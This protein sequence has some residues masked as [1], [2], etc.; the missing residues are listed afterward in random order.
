MQDGV[1]S[2][3]EFKAAVKKVCVGKSYDS[4]PQA[5]KAFVDKMFAS[6]DLNG[7]KGTAFEAKKPVYAA[8]LATHTC[9]ITG[10]RWQLTRLT[11][12]DEFV[13]AVW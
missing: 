1:V 8:F 13:S 12:F 9:V 3:D 5:L 4:F 10:E 2:I 11:P 6:I 7:K